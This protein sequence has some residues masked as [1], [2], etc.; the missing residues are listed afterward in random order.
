MSDEVGVDPE[1]LNQAASALENLRNTLAANVPTIVNTMNSYWSGGTGSPISLSVLQQ[2]QQH[3]VDDALDIRNRATLALLWQQQHVS[4]TG[5]W[6]TI[7]WDSQADEGDDAATEVQALKEAEALKNTSAARAEIE[8]IEQDLQDQTY[9]LQNGDA[10]DKATAEAFL[11]SFYAGAGTQVANLAATLSSEDGKGLTPLSTADQRIL[12]GYAS[13]LAA[14]DKSGGVNQA[15]IDGFT[16]AP[17]MWSVAMLFKFGP[18]GSDYATTTSWADGKNGQPGT[19]PPIQIGLLA[20]VTAAVFTASQNGSFNVPVDWTQEDSVS[21]QEQI[22]PTLQEY[23]PLAAMLAVDTQNQV[24]AGQV[25]A[26]PHYGPAIAKMLEQ[27]PTMTYLENEGSNGGPANFTVM[28]SGEKYGPDFRSYMYNQQ[29]IENFLDAATTNPADPGASPPRTGALGYQAAMAAMNIIENTPDPSSITVTNQVRQALLTTYGRY[30]PDLAVSSTISPQ[31]SASPVPLNS[32]GVWN[33]EMYGGSNTSPVAVFMRQ[34]AADP[35]D[36]GIMQ[37]ETA[38][39]LGNQYAQQVVGNAQQGPWSDGL[40]QDLASLYGMAIT[41]TQNYRYQGAEAED[42]AHGEINTLISMAEAGASLVPGVGEAVPIAV[43]LIPTLSTDNASNQAAQDLISYAEQE[44]ALNITMVQG[45]INAGVVT[46]QAS[47]YQNGQIVPNNAF[48]QWWQHHLNLSAASLPQYN[49]PD[50]RYPQP[51]TKP[52][53]TNNDN[54]ETIEGWQNK[55]AI[56]NMDLTRE[57][58]TEEGN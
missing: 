40:A 42:V 49:G 52:L 19:G 51:G 15:I 28:G 8:A 14:L 22:T 48:E 9:A 6:V 33:L 50:W 26:D 31:S 38:S 1:R 17:N 11:K 4:L 55:F 53:I 21:G 29:L 20:Q 5:V 12:N 35:T 39:A 2:A 47:W 3:S 7:P 23:D 46:P 25:L 13:A 10:A 27:E 45:L 30:M 41:Q 34:I 58:Q 36:A 57:Q 43:P 37:G 54:R 44:S 16:K 56:I 24:A 18:S 32:Y